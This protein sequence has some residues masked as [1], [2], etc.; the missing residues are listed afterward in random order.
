MAIDG[1]SIVAIN[2][3]WWLIYWWLFFVII[4]YI[5]TVGGYFLLL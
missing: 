1:Y 2:D 5:M 3:Y 4:N